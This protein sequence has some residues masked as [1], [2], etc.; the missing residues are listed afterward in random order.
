MSF[1][2]NLNKTLDAIREKPELTHSQLNE[3]KELKSYST[4]AL[5]AASSKHKYDPKNKYDPKKDVDNSGVDPQYSMQQIRDE[6][7]SRTKEVDEGAYQGGPDKSQIPAVNRPG[8]K[9]T[10]QD[11]EKE[12]NQ[13]PTTADGMRALQNK[14][15]NI[16]PMDKTM[17]EAAKYRDAKYKDRKSVV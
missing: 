14:L 11:L 17:D 1:F 4:D 16:H 2:Y 7:K 5:K 10:L 3:R 13:S 8:N 9:M 6:L 15:K 12:R